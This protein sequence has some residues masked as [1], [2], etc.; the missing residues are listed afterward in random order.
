MSV[1]EERVSAPPRERE[2]AREERARILEAAALEIEVRGWTQ[3]TDCDESGRVC[4]LGAIAFASGWNGPG[5]RGGIGAKF[6]E[7]LDVWPQLGEPQR[8]NDAEGRTAE[9]VTLLLRL[10]AEEVRRGR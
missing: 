1:V 4:A 2:D 9:E 10:R 5:S 8:F 6:F 7:A 3:H